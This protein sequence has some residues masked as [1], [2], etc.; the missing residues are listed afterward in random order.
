MIRRLLR[1]FEI[2]GARNTRCKDTANDGSK[3]GAGN[4]A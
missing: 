4:V 2:S 1:L 3:D